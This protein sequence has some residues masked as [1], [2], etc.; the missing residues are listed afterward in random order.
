MTKFA[1]FDS[2]YFILRPRI[3]HDF[4][5][6]ATVP[7][8][9]PRVSRGKSDAALALQSCGRLRSASAIQAIYPVYPALIYD[10]LAVSSATVSWY[11]TEQ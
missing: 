2:P 1:S 6:S 11:A 7:V 10:K 5:G 9:L 8:A 3:M 4:Q